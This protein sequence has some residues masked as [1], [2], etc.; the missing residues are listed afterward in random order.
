MRRKDAPQLFEIMR[1]SMPAKQPQP[2][3]HKERPTP[4]KPADVAPAAPDPIAPPL[5]VPPTPPPEAAVPAPA[6]S[7]SRESAPTPVSPPTPAMPPP[8]PE[9][10]FTVAPPKPKPR[11]KP[12]PFVLRPPA[13]GLFET[14]PEQRVILS[15]PAALASTALLFSLLFA[16]F[17]IGRAMT[18]VPPPNAPPLPAPRPI[19][20]GDM[21]RLSSRPAPQPVWTLCL[22]E[23]NVTRPAD[24]EEAVRRLDLIQRR[25]RERFNAETRVIRWT[26][27]GQSYL[28]LAYGSWSDPKHPDLAAIAAKLKDLEPFS[29]GLKP[30]EKCRVLQEPPQEPPDR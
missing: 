18:P 16:A 5:I 26:E 21:V 19:P 25:L 3:T 11:R 29:R 23:L 8:L 20:A 4:S 6:V 9:P 14:G 30:F 24:N 12:K 17:M 28:G 15:Y 22:V 7:P 13:P 10:V 1:T 27:R 2:P